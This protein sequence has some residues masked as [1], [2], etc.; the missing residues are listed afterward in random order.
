MNLTIV[1]FRAV[2]IPLNSH[3]LKMRFKIDQMHIVAHRGYSH[4]YPDNTLLSYIRA[5]EEGADF[6]EVD[7]MVTAE[8]RIFVQHNLLS[9]GKAIREMTYQEAIYHNWDVPKIEDVI[10]ITN[11]FGRGIY[12]DIK[13]RESMKSLVE[14]LKK[15]HIPEVVV[16]SFDAR[17]IKG[18]KEIHPVKTALLIG[19][20]Y[21]AEFIIEIAKHYR[22]DI[23]HPAWES[24]HPY[25]HHLIGEMLH[26]FRKHGFEV[27]SWHEERA[28]VLRELFEMGM[29]Y[30]STND[31]PLA[32]SIRNSLTVENE[33]IQGI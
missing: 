18:I 7:V 27:S 20:V 3:R 29:D 25:P 17:F 15:F 33:K 4:L 5:F 10:G 16:S 12:F 22:A 19:S 28:D 1:V 6:I 8:R 32:V 24:R 26:Q 23:I 21:D 2:I 30:I 9:D 11:D 13:D 31:V 14:I